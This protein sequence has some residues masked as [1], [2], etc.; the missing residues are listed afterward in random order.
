MQKS[1]SSQDLSNLKEIFNTKSNNLNFIKR[2]T[3]AFFQ[4][5]KI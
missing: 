3:E 2:K 5:N 4:Y 1:T